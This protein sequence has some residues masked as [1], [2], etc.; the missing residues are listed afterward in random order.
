M[1]WQKQN[2]SMGLMKLFRM[3]YDPT[4]KTIIRTFYTFVRI[5]VDICSKVWYPLVE[6]REMEIIIETL[7]P[8]ERIK[9]EPN[10]VFK[11][12]DT[13][14]QAILL[15]DNA[16]A[17]IIMKPQESAIVSQ[18][19]AKSLP[20]SSAYTLQE[21]MRI[22]LLDAEGNEMHAAELADAIYERGLYVQKNGEKA[23]YNQMRAR[24]G[25][26]PEMFEALKGNIIR[27]RTENEAN[28]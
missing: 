27:L 20:M 2:M 22:V 28:V 8:F 3:G 12:V 16:P 9:K 21:A 11:I 25:H 24:C 14:G 6:V 1:V 23:K 18:E 4:S 17:Y 5:I 15:K 7:I 13:Y 10:D 19:Q 26:Y